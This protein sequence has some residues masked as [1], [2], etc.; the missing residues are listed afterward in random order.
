MTAG[1]GISHSEMF[2]LL[3]RAAP[4]P[5]ELFQIWLNLPKADKM[6]PPHFTMLWDEG[7]PRVKAAGV[8]VTVVAGALEGHRAPS[9]PPHSWASRPDTDVAIWAIK[10][11]PGA[12]W[13]LPAA[14]VGVNR[15]L[16]LF[17]GGDVRVDGRGIAPPTGIKLR[18]DVAVLLENGAQSAELLLLQGRPIAEPVVQHGPFVMNT[19]TEIQEAFSEY[20][21]TR[22][23]GW[24]WKKDD[25]VHG[26]DAGRF[27]RHADGREERPALAPSRAKD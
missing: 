17:E 6:V 8:E 14:S 1:R 11:D 16:Y 26:R 4:N 9:P 3:D 24:P 15:N 13:S 20:R 21:S 22:F 10:L 19:S 5:M 27:A 18:P 2:P 23:G 7:I 25:P 12:R